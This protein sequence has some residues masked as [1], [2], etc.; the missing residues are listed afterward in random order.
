MQL[1]LDLT[2]P[3]ARQPGSTPAKKSDGIYSVSEIT[4]QVR[5][6]LERGFGDIWVEGEISNFRPYPTGRLYFSIKDADASLSCVMFAG[7]AAS[8]GTTR[9]ADGLRVE[10]HGK[11]SVFEKRGQYQ[12]VV[13]QARACGAGALHAKFEALKKKLEA[14]GL[15]APEKK[16]SLPK[17]PA[18]IGVVTSP[19]GAAIRDFLN[20]LHRRHPGIGVVINPVRVQGSGAAAEI[21]RAVREFGEPGRWGLPPVDVIVVTRGGGSIEDLW[22]FNEEAVARAIAASPVPVVSAVGHEIDFT[23]CD[24]ASDYRAP[25]PS[26]A[27]EILSADAAEVRMR[28]EREG[29][30]MARACAGVREGLRLQLDGALGSALFR[31][32]LR[33]VEEYAQ[34]LDRTAL[35]LRRAPVECL[36]Q[37]HHRLLT[38]ETA[39][40]PATLLEKIENFRLRLDRASQ[41][42]VSPAEKRVATLLASLGEL[43]GKIFALDP[44][45]VLERGFTVTLDSAGVVLRT[46]SQARTAIRIQ[47]RFSDGTIESKV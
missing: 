3:P 24:F 41:R 43:S 5:S 11:L 13:R 10:L 23:I 47:T 33:Q 12:L 7:D 1:N 40:A 16:R 44:A 30:R 25:T 20:V 9:L 4:R 45:R 15:F 2:A 26:A 22:E 39:M 17:F 32:P 38:L 31:D 35:D 14:E 46:V 36:R 42:L 37:L 6:C 28:L 19:A 29:R 18:R 21:A 27:A 8:L 34:R